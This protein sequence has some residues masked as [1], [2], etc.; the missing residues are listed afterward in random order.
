[1]NARDPSGAWDEADATPAPGVRRRGPADG[2]T[3]LVFASP[4]SGDLYPDDPGIDP[5]LPVASLRSAEDALIDRIAA[6]AAARIGAP[7]LCGLYGRAWLDLNRAPDDLDPLVIDGLDIPEPGPRARA[8]Y[9]VI[10]RLT[11]DG[12]PLRTA[13]LPLAV[14]RARLEGPHAAYHA[15]L[16]RLMTSARARFGCAVLVDWHSM[17]GRAVANGAAARPLDVVLGDRHGRACDPALMRRAR[18][19][20]ERAGWR[21]GLNHPYA[22]G[23]STERWGRPDEGFHALQIEINRD[24]YLAPDLTPGPGF[25]RV[26]S[27][28]LALAAALA[29]ALAGGAAGAKVEPAGGA[30]KKPRPKARHE[31]L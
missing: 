5:T 8:G 10:P 28:A 19:A 22:G 11:G 26:A 1:M 31:S 27:V 24:L 29:E 13:P 17:P 7:L 16:E 21:V 2:A 12:R 20:L 3:P 25:G 14:A 18:A 15:E 30:K 4:H 23:W 6:P 9:G